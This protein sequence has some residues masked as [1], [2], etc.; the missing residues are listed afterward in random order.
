[1]SAAN[2]ELVRRAMQAVNDRDI[3]TIESTYAEDVVYR[4]IGGLA[5]M[6][7]TEFRGR[8]ALL[9]WF[10]EWNETMDARVDIDT[11]REVN[12]QVLAIMNLNA[13]GAASGAATTRLFGQVFSFRD[14]RISAQ[15]AYY[16]PAEA[17]EA[18]GL[19]DG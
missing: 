16:T 7:G 13:A 15:D 8:D 11:I 5:D 14:G 17:L 1:M 6:M 3:P 2:V 4:L 10:R 9:G 18:V 19:A 12:D